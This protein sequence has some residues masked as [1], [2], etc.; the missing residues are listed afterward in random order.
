MVLGGDFRQVL[1]VVV[2]GSRGQIV[3]A[4]LKR[5]SLWQHA[6][7]LQL[8]INERVLRRGNSEKYRDFAEFILQVGNAQLNRTNDL[9]EVPQNL[10]H[11]GNVHDLLLFTQPRMSEGIFDPNSAVLTPKNEHSDY[12]N[13]LALQHLGGS[14]I[15]LL[16]NDYVKDD[17]QS[18]LYPVEFLN[19]LQVSGMPPHKL[20]LREGA[21][22]MLMRNLSPRQ[23]L[24]NGTRLR[25]LNF[26]STVLQAEV[27]SGPAAGNTVL[28][29]R[30][31]MS[32]STAILPF[33]MVRRQFPVKLAF[34]L[35]INKSQ[36][37]TL[38]K[39]AVYLPT[40]VFTHGQL[41]VCTSRTGDP[42]NLKIMI[43]PQ[44]SGEQGCASIDGTFRYF[45]KNIVYREV[46]R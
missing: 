38:D 39:V 11:T 4:S 28:I 13:N 40:P 25:L 37:Q 17:A 24:C 16:S 7:E 10:I 41:Y 44:S 2:K 12:I 32:P 18:A 43:V 9:L 20:E 36:G 1:P 26:R 8:S 30:I 23:G 35:T 6:V 31:C 42:D 45:T 21:P 5:S 15:T 34:A 19:S 22:I 29:P 46:L 27:I 3:D 14:T 33:D